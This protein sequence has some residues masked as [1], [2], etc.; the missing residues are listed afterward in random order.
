M[1]SLQENAF[2][3]FINNF[4]DNPI[5]EHKLMKYIM[6]N[7]H[8]VNNI[9]NLEGLYHVYLIE[10]EYSSIKKHG[11]PITTF[12]TYEESHKWILNNGKKYMEKYM[13]TYS[14]NSSEEDSPLRFNIIY[15]ENYKLDTAFDKNSNFIS[16]FVFSKNDYNRLCQHYDYCLKAYYDLV[17]KILYLIENDEIIEKKYK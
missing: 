5:F 2:D 4:C 16:S 11:T 9:I 1:E 3:V 10:N 17:P 13:D 12:L 7:K 15:N 8:I 14:E 6:K